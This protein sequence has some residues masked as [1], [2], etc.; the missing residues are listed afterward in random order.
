MYKK[1]RRILGV[2]T[3]QTSA[4]A[5]KLNLMKA[6]FYYLD[7]DIFLCGCLKKLHTQLVGQLFAALKRNHPLILHVTL[8]A[9]Q[10]NLRIIPGVRFYLC[11][12]V[13]VGGGGDHEM[14]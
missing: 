2:G 4:S 13:G 10:Y 1:N 5:N 12:P 7:I 14:E 6:C 11:H 3:R 9:D 8:I